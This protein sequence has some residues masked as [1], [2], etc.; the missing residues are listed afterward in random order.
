[1]NTPS[2]RAGILR[3]ALVGTCSAL[4]TALA[5]AAGGGGLPTGSAPIELLIVCATIGAG[6]GA[7]GAER[8]CARL[9]MAVSALAAGQGLG[10]LT[11]AGVGGHH[12]ADQAASHPLQMLA[13]HAS[14]AVVLGSLIAAVEYLYLICVSV[15]S[16]LR[17]FATASIDPA[18]AAP[19]RRSNVVVRRPVL[20]GSGLGTRAP[21]RALVLGA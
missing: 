10:H 4:V 7:L 18:P 5:H 14:A 13:L 8:R 6:V 20:L 17:L 3:G 11:L 15:L 21:P 19:T 9:T 12:H 16:W 2:S 1:M